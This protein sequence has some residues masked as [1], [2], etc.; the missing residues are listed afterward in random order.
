MPEACRFKSVD[1]R[2]RFYG[3]SKSI[4]NDFLF[5]KSETRFFEIHP[6]LTLFSVKN[7]TLSA[8]AQVEARASNSSILLDLTR[9]GSGLALNLDLG[10]GHW[11][12][13]YLVLCFLAKVGGELSPPTFDKN[14]GVRPKSF[15][16]PDLRRPGWGFVL[17][18][19]AGLGL[20]F[21]KVKFY[22]FEGQGRSWARRLLW[23]DQIGDPTLKNGVFFKAPFLRGPVTKRAL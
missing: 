20:A 11:S 17:K 14:D 18:A 13:I 15:R 9:Q 21:E 12:Q 22:F 10:P 6:F 19:G 7:L 3:L 4:Y 8:R 1:F 5:R 16:P 2:N 23:S